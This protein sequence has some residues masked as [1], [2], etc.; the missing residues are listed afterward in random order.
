MKIGPAQ[1]STLDTLAQAGFEREMTA[2]LRDF[3]PRH[4]RTLGDDALTGIVAYG[5]QQAAAYGFT[6]RGPVRLYLEMMILFGSKFDRDPMFAWAG[7]YL[8]NIR[9]PAQMAR[10][11]RLHGATTDYINVV[12]G[13]RYTFEADAI[14]RLLNLD[15]SLWITGA[16]GLREIVSLYPQKAA[17]GGRDACLQLWDAADKEAVKAGLAGPAARAVFCALMLALG[18]FVIEDPQFPWIK[19][20]ISNSGPLAER[21][22]LVRLVS[23]VYTFLYAA[24]QTLE[25]GH[26]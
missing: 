4:A 8:A 13:I 1:Y 18:R 2:H 17:Y 10:A 6:L 12:F 14:R 5:R 19:A 24:L 20:E 3:A 25:N 26:A 9:D 21:D 7:H 16:Q 23:K 22:R 15:Q 11:N